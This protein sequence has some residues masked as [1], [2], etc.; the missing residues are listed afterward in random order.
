MATSNVSIANLALQKLGAASIVALDATPGK[1][2]DLS[3]CFESIRDDELRKYYWK[4]AIT[5]A[6]LAPH[7]TAPNVN[8]GYAYAHVLPSDFLRLMKPARL[9]LDW[10]IE[11][12]E[13]QLCILTNDANTLP[14]RYIARITDP[15]AFDPCFVQMFACKLAWQCCERIT[16][17]NTKREAMM[18][19][20]NIHRADARKTNAFEMPTQAQPVDEWLTGRSSGQLVNSEW[21]EE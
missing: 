11:R 7:A 21:N 2:A 17:S 6:V 10:H 1:A 9:N 19:E 15:T 4:F 14:I 16:Q 13:G 18:T 8:I 3:S 12:H 20:Y 5:R